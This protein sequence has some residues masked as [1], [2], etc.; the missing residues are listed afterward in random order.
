[1]AKWLPKLEKTLEQYSEGSH[2]SYR[3]FMSAEPA[4]I[5]E[6]H[7]IPQVCMCV[8]NMYMHVHVAGNDIVM[9]IYVLGHFGIFYQN[10][11]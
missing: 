9:S 11:K 6:S 4:P 2:E 5:P 7:I 3:V 8:Y 10:Y 1:M